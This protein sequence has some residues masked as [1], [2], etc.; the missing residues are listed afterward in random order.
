MSSCA[1]FPN[2]SPASLRGNN[3]APKTQ[4]WKYRAPK[5]MGAERHLLC[6]QLALVHPQYHLCPMSTAREPGIAPEHC[7]VWP[8]YCPSTPNRASRHPPTCSVCENS[9][10]SPGGIHV[11]SFASFFPSRTSWGCIF[12][13]KMTDTGPPRQVCPWA[14]PV[15]NPLITAPS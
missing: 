11:S 3:H 1:N 9:A 8:N 4:T 6:I 15:E 5:F 7:Q 10:A 2:S 12:R 13:T 14:V